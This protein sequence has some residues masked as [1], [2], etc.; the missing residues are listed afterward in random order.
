MA[1]TEELTERAR[2]MAES[3][4]QGTVEA[5]NAYD[6]YMDD[7]QNTE[8]MENESLAEEFMYEEGEL[9]DPWSPGVM[10][11]LPYAYG[12]NVEKVLEITLAGGGPSMWIR[13]KIDASECYDVELW[14]SWGE[15]KEYHLNWEQRDA[16]T[17]W[18][19]QTFGGIM[20]ME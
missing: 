20:E 18:I 16:V 9:E 12:Y 17:R 5:F 4:A 10:H 19:D 15:A 13:C 2:S 11:S 3:F 1:T 7:D 8:D 14:Y 6:W